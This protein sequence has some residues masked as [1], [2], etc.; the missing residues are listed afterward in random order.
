MTDRRAYNR[1]LYLLQ[2]A[3]RLAYMKAQYIKRRELIIAQVRIWRARNESYSSYHSMMR[4][5]CNPKAH[6]FAEYG[7]RGITVCERW[8][9]N[10]VNFREDMGKRPA[11]YS[12][13][14]IDNSKGY[15]PENCRWADAKTQANN[16]RLKLC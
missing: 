11:G 16:R 8:R 2:R 14:R 4:R 13:D 7:G 10:Y 1:A 3:E 12:I 9:G 6:N 5:C 15:S